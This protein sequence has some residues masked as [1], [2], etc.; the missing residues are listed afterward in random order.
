M[1]MV[2]QAGMANY[3]KCSLPGWLQKYLRVKTVS[4]ASAR[5]MGVQA[6]EDG[7]PLLDEGTVALA[8]KVF[9]NCWS[10]AFWVIQR[11]HADLSVRA[12]FSADRAWRLLGWRRPH[13]HVALRQFDCARF[14]SRG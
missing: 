6:Y 4:I 7:R 13:L 8:L 14:G 2:A 12:G 11:L 10:W 1:L 9:P 5:A 3:Y